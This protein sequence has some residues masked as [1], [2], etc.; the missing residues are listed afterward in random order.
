MTARPA[1]FLP[2]LLAFP[3]TL[4]L[5]AGPALADGLDMS[6]GE[7]VQLF[8]K[9]EEVYDRNAQTV[10][11]TG[12]GRA[13][14]G[15]VTVDAD[16]L[17]GYLRK[18][19]PAP[20]QQAAPPPADAKTG[21]SSDPMGGSLELY[22]IEARGNVHIYNQTDQGWGDHALYDMD[23][24]VMV[25]T[26]KHLKLTTPQDVLTARDVME[27]HSKTRMSVGRGDATVT[28]NDGK[29][30]KADVLV[31]FSKASDAPAPGQP[32]A[33]AS[34]PMGGG[35]SKLDRAYG[36]GHVILRTQTQTAT[37]DRGVYVFDTE[38]A[39]LIGHVHVT[40]GQNQ[41]NGSQA[42]VNMKTGIATMLPGTDSPI[43]G[44]VVPNEAN[45]SQAPK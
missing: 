43:Q 12:G 35:S 30:V 16:T 22:R 11:L 18:K 31:S 36:W 39:R 45:S 1:A 4:A 32:A 13:V 7:A 40:Q 19:A 23:Q 5:P 8:W 14:R 24:A 15:D 20:G 29:Q 17:I 26:G 33:D 21:S 28:T 2:F 25:M 9:N 34:N 38:I 3:L 6:H 44:L 10:T 41:N 37:G 27:Y 42:I